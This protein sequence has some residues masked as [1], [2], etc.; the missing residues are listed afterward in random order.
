MRGECRVTLL[1]ALLPAFLACTDHGSGEVE[2]RLAQKPA[3]AVLAEVARTRYSPPASGRLEARQVELYLRVSERAIA[4]REAA[5]GLKSGAGQRPSR[6]AETTM[7]DA[8]AAQELHFNPKEYD[9]IKAR[10]IET[11]TTAAT[12]VLQQ[13]VAAGREQ[14]LRHLAVERDAQTDATQKA[15]ATREIDELRRAFQ[16]SEPNVPA[17]VEANMRLLAHYRE[18]LGRLAKLDQTAL[19][20]AAVAHEP[21][22]GAA[23]SPH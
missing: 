11:Q 8:R 5:A 19:V 23:L 18:R 14:L 3:S 10:V 17:A 20:R 6:L 1:G 12:R 15:D 13:K 16:E 7:A 2:R 4:I 21:G 9:W 22:E